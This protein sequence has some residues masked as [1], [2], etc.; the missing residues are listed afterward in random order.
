MNDPLEMVRALDLR[1]V[2]L[3]LE[4]AELAEHPYHKAPTYYFRM[5]SAASGVED[6]HD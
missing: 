2:D 5:I 3:R 4:F 6:G 1:D